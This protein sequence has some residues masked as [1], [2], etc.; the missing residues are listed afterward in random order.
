MNG[1]GPM[2]W[3]DRKRY[4]VLLL[5]LPV[6]LGVYLYLAGVVIRT[7][8]QDLTASDQGAEIAMAKGAKDDWFPRQTDGVRHPLWS[9][10]ARLVS[11]P[12]D[13]RFFANGK[14][15][16]TTLCMVF[17][18][19][20]AVAITRVFDVLAAITWTSLAGLGLLVVRGTY[21]Q[22]EPL[23]Y[24][25]S[26]AAMILGWWILRGARAWMYP[27]F[28]VVCGLAYLA[29]PSL[30]PFLLVFGAAV[31]VRTILS[32]RRA[33]VTWKPAW[34]LGGLLG[35]AAIMAAMLVPLAVFSR[36]HF[37]KPLFNYTKYW[38]WMDDFMTE[39]WPWQD[40]YPGRAQ[41][42]QLPENERPS[43]G[44]YLQRHGVSGLGRRLAGGTK[45]VAAR[46]F[47]PEP[48]M[49]WKAVFWKGG[50]EARNKWG[51]PVTHRG[52]YLF[53]L[54][55]LVAVLAV[56]SAREVAAAL[57]QP[58]NA[59]ALFYVLGLA[60]FYTLLYGWY[61]PIG[62]GDRF[63]GSLW[64]PALF[65]LIAC[66]H[67]MRGRRPGAEKIYLAVHGAILLSLALQALNAIVLFQQ[68]IFLR[69]R[70]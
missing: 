57:G 66:A 25:L 53:A 33:D 40:R 3:L 39:A 2:D 42:D 54:G 48:K 30:L 67:R 26:F 14:W 5:T 29:K 41:L 24:I 51:H 65:F 44:R 18:A 50:R 4:F 59:A 27:V 35:S 10:T 55:A 38:M 7:S 56:L 62:R 15:L 20:M 16:N 32:W 69:T 46:F 58:G 9:W 12:D 43:L 11:A 61:Y 63:M 13:N 21:F 70:N 68:E 23:Y 37:G 28:G 34:V 19:V 49:S 47:F 22:P 45:E 64:M 1:V 17:L 52:I 8:N 6:V 36:D 31:A 60:G